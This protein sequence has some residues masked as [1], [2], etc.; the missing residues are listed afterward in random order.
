MS[1]TLVPGLQEHLDTR[2]TTMCYCWKV[3]RRDGV[4]QGFTEH[5]EDVVFD[6]VTYAAQTGF[7][8][9]KIQQSLGLSADNLNVSGALSA[10]TINDDDLAA[11]LYDDAEVTLYWVNWSNVLENVVMDAGNIGEVTREETAFSAEF[12]SLLHRLN[13]KNGRLYQRDCDAILGDARCGVDLT[14]PAFSKLGVVTS[15]TG[16]NL[17]LTGLDGVT[18]DFFTLGVL[19]FSAGGNKDLSF[20]VKQQTGSNVVLWDIPPETVVV[21]DSFVLTAGCPKKSD[22]C[23]QKFANLANFRGF[24]HIPGNDI[25]SA[26]PRKEDEKLDGGS[27]FK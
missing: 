16:R 11:G 18:D 27:W 22:A 10:D 23:A 15:G 9:S 24:S 3:T 1:K 12:R 7:S 2:S 17:I 5:D 21:G 8:A 25:L 19:T 6:G 13:Q 14:N 26:Y 4:V 20:E